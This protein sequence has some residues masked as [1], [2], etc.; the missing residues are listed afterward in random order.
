MSERRR[1]QMDGA[2]RGAE[3]ISL[4]RGAL[5]AFF[6]GVLGRGASR[7]APPVIEHELAGFLVVRPTAQSKP[8]VAFKGAC[9]KLRGT[10]AAMRATRARVC[11]SLGALVGR[12]FAPPRAQSVF[13]PRRCNFAELFRPLKIESASDEENEGR[14]ADS[15]PHGPLSSRRLSS[16]I[17]G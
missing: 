15:L 9:Q 3:Q 5:S 10:H 14:E 13:E 12:D 7:S 16:G 4:T 1:T 2:L 8:D 11:S 17:W 6:T